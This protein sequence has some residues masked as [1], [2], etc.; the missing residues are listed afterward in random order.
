MHREDDGERV[1]PVD[2]LKPRDDAPEL[3]GVVDVLL[4]VGSDEEV[5]LRLKAKGVENVCPLLRDLP[6]LEDRIDDGIP[7][8]ADLILLDPLVQEILPCRLRG[9]EEIIRNMV[10]DHPVD[11]LGHR[12]VEAPEAGLD[13]TDPDVK[14][15]G[16]KS[17]GHDSVGVALNE[18][19]TRGLLHQNIL[20]TGHDLCGLAG[21]GPG[22]DVEVI[23]RLGQFKILKKRPIHI[24]RVVLPGVEDE[25]V[26]VSR[27]A[28]PNDRGHLDGLGPGAEDDRNH[29]IDS[30]EGPAPFVIIISE[31]KINP[32]VT[33]INPRISAANPPVKTM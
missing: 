12:P 18:N 2:R 7:G 22:T 33:S 6:V 24:I 27:F 30:F 5:A 19:N 25:V 26:E 28:F 17:P 23:L 21:L 32:D 31:F 15:R 3:L 29:G 13:M 11:L 9:G 10:R 16:C 4:P 1:L 8:Y 20:D 14:L